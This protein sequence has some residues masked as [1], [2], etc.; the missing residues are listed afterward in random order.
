V[1]A[2][3]TKENAEKKTLG[4][5]ILFTYYDSSAVGAKEL[6]LNNE[7]FKEFYRMKYDSFKFLVEILTEGNENDTQYY[8][9]DVSL[10]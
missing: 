6:S 7:K 4:T 2:V 9:L 5:L 8:Q 1:V 10:E 3:E